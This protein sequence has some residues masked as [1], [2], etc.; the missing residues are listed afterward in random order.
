M[1]RINSIVFI[2]F[3]AIFFCVYLIQA[4]PYNI[5]FLM[6]IIIGIHSI[7]QSIEEVDDK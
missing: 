6:I 1:S 7:I 2:V 5:I 3:S 4:L